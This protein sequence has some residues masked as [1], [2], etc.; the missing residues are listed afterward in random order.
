MCGGTRLVVSVKPFRPGA[1]PPVITIG[2]KNTEPGAGRTCPPSLLQNLA[3]CPIWRGWGRVMEVELASPFLGQTSSLYVWAP[4]VSF[5][6]PRFSVLY[7]LVWK[8]AG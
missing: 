8:E 6:D 3:L 4:M 2:G 5:L 7:N 1:S